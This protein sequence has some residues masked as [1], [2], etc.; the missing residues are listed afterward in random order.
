MR[1]TM[2]ALRHERWSYLR[3]YIATVS[4]SLSALYQT[5]TLC[6]HECLYLM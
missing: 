5:A 1:D 2:A 6:G 4:I 3:L